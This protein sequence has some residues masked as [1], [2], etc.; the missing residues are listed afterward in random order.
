MKIR[1]Y[2]NFK[3]TPESFS[4]SVKSIGNAVFS[5]NVSK[6]SS[7]GIMRKIDNFIRRDSLKHGNYLVVLVDKETDYYNS[8]IGD[9]KTIKDYVVDCLEDEGVA[10]KYNKKRT[11][12]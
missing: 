5:V 10:P 2:E 3:E 7:A 9:L 11:C 6:Y 1:I 4:H 12:S 8:L